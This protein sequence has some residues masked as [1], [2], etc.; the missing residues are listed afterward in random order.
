MTRAA[1]LRGIESPAMLSVSALEPGCVRAAKARV[2]RSIRRHAMAERLHD[3][4]VHILPCIEGRVEQASPFAQA[5][6][7]GSILPATW[8]LMLALR[9]RGLGTG[10]EDA[11][12]PV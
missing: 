9:A 11:P 8:T 5:S 1:V 6:R 7:Y 3:V 12:S 10:L 2:W 4:P